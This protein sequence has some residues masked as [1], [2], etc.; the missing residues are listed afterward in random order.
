[1]KQKFYSKCP[2]KIPAGGSCQKT[3]HVQSQCQWNDGTPG[4]TW[5]ERHT[6]DYLPH[7][8]YNNRTVYRKSEPD[9]NGNFWFLFKDD[10]SHSSWSLDWT[11]T[12]TNFRGQTEMSDIDLTKGFNLESDHLTNRTNLAQMSCWFEVTPISTINS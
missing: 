11:T 2:L 3:V 1:M 10:I 8:I 6:G 4:K 5:H 12:K 7:S 9:K